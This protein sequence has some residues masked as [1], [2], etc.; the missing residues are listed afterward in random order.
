MTLGTEKGYFLA[1][2]L[3]FCAF[4]VASVADGIPEE[5]P[6]TSLSCGFSVLDNGDT[7]QLVQKRVSDE[8]IRLPPEFD[9]VLTHKL[10]CKQPD[11]LSSPCLNGGSCV[12]TLDGFEC[13]CRSGYYGPVC[14]W[15]CPDSWIYFRGSCYGYFSEEAIFE[16]ALSNCRGVKI[17]GRRANI[18]S[19]HSRE[20]LNFIW[21]MEGI[22]PSVWLGRRQPG[23]GSF[24]TWTDGSP[25]DFTNWAPGQP[26]T[27]KQ[28]VGMDMDDGK[29]L[30]R[31]C[32]AY[33][34]SYFCK[35]DITL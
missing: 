14:A 3:V 4:I 5:C 32:R 20:E 27:D 7:I 22:N 35:I 18:L 2:F 30:T 12:E 25:V 23:G 6:F 31:M 9:R 16:T 24:V 8:D 33:A 17:S 29:W 34:R 26:D 21:N 13:S 28:C 10:I 1:I 15:T 19:I 11:C